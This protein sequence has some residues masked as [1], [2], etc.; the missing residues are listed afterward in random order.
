MRTQRVG[1]MTKWDRDLLEFANDFKALH[2]FILLYIFFSLSPSLIPIF[3][4]LFFSLLFPLPGL[5]WRNERFKV[6]IFLVVDI[7]IQT[8]ITFVIRTNK[9]W[10]FKLIKYIWKIGK[11]NNFRSLWFVIWI[12]PHE[13]IWLMILPSCVP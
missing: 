12:H 1:V 13:P 9:Y 2:P 7:P 10:I 3:F 11:W 4:I 5:N 6:S 8:H